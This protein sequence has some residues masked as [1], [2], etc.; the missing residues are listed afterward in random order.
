MP[1]WVVYSHSNRGVYAIFDRRPCDQGACLYEFHLA[2]ILET[3]FNA[4]QR[5]IGV[6]LL[7]DDIPFSST[8]CSAE[9]KEGFP[10]DI[11]FPYK[12]LTGISR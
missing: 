5:R 11:T 7:L 3:P 12:G 10:G 2:K 6:A 4:L 9:G 8:N 1:P